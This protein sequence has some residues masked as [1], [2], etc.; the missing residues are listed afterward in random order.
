MN[1]NS[2]N[3]SAGG[4]YDKVRQPGMIST[5]SYLRLEQSIQGSFTSVNFNVLQNQGTA[6]V[7]EK[8]LAITDTFTITSLS[9]MIFKA[10]AG[11]TA[12]QVEISQSLLQLWAN[13]QV[14]T[15]VGEAAALRALYNGNMQI[16]VDGTVYIDSLDLM[17]FWRPG[18]SQQGMGSDAA[19][20]AKVQVN[21][22]PAVSFGF[23][24][25]VPTITLSGAGKNEI[26]LNIPTS[27]S[28]AGTSSQN[29]VVCYLRGLLNQNASR[30]NGQ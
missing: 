11:T 8:R 12:T 1:P 21:E 19:N 10:G 20:N 28:F 5:P 30:L 15:G 13:P 26:S 29:F 24:K 23:N 22:W 14:F 17:R 25:L 2:S 18:T 7:T 16:K 27:T 6:N 4:V 3:Y 9:V